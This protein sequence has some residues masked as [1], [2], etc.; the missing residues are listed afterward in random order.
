MHRMT[1]P[2]VPIWNGWLAGG[3]SRPEV[4]PPLRELVDSICVEVGRDPATVERTVSV[5]IDP[6]G[7][8]EFPKHWYLQDALTGAQA[9]PLTGIV[10]TIAADLRAFGAIGSPTS[11]STPFHPTWRRSSPSF[12][13]SK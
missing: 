5:S 13:S 9:H 12:R 6:S 8:R 7:R 10:D 1:L 4:Y 2:T 3:D 11:R